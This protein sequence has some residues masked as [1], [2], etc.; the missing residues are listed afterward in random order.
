MLSTLRAE[1]GSLNQVAQVL[2]VFGM[3]NV[4]PGFDDLAAG[5]QLAKVLDGCTS[6]LAEVFGNDAG[7]PARVAV[8]MAELP[9]GAAVETEMTVALRD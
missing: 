2:K 4:S 9:P 8:G 1:I 3:V 6:Q 5:G 7:I